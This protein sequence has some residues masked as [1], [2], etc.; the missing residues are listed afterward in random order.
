MELFGGPPLGVPTPG[1]APEP[2]NLPLASPLMR[3]D[4]CNPVKFP[5]PPSSHDA[6]PLQNLDAPFLQTPALSAHQ[7][8]AY[9]GRGGSIDFGPMG[10]SS[11]MADAGLALQG[12]LPGP[13]GG[14]Q[15]PPFSDI[16]GW[17][18]ECGSDVGS[19]PSIWSRA[20][21]QRSGSSYA[22]AGDGQRLI[23]IKPQEVSGAT[24]GTVVIG[25]KKE[26]PEQWWNH[27]EILL[28]GGKEGQLKLKPSGIRKGKKLCI[29][30]P[31]ALECRDYDVRVVFGG[32]I[33]HG[34]IPLAVRGDDS[35]SEKEE[36]DL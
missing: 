22:L 14:Q 34:A 23:F 18:W 17:S 28:V 2:P 8:L 7:A 36:E 4:V 35:E 9:P 25:L 5:Q 3:N 15:K 20:S 12:H 10:G 13:P 26:I 30:V 29:K 16:F 32:K 19:L 11:L 24:G 31:P 27:V 6:E 1:E 21:T 33:L